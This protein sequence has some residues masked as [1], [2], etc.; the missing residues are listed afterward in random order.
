MRR[1]AVGKLLMAG[2][3]A[4]LVYAFQ[5]FLVH[6][7]WGRR[8]LAWV[9][10]VAVNSGEPVTGA[11]ASAWQTNRVISDGYAW[12]SHLPW[13]LTDNTYFVLA[14]A[15]LVMRLARRLP[16][17]LS[18]AV[19]LPAA[20]YG[21]AAGIADFPWLAIYWPLTLVTLLAAW[22]LVGYTTRWH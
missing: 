14:I 16:G 3:I 9:Y 13:G 15:C 17:W 11:T 2:H 18:L 4:L 7:Q 12:V 21:L 20:V 5:A 8:L 10:S 6:P 22:I 19:A 1:F